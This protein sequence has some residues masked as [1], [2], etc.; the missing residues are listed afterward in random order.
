VELH[1][2]LGLGGKV[3]GIQL[4]ERYLDPQVAPLAPENILV[5]TPSSIAAFGMSGSNRFGAFTKSPLTGIWLES[6]CGG[7]F[8]RVFGET[9]WGA[10]VISGAAQAPV[11]IHVITEGAEIRSAAGLWGQDTFVTE[12]RLLADLDKR[13][14]VLSIGV[15]GENLVKVA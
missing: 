7:S 15:A 13:S 5:F 3:L 11:H 6:Y 12:A 1:D 2:T 10:V 4:L 8:A 9:G 14:A